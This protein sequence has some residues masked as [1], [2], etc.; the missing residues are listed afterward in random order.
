MRTSARARFL[1]AAASMFGCLLSA[2]TAAAAGD[3]WLGRDKFLHFGVSA[4]IAG[5]SYAVSSLVFEERWQRAV[6]GGSVALAA[7]AGKELYDL[8]GAGDASWKDFAWDV[9]GAAVGVGVALAI[10]FALGDSG[11]Q[12]DARGLALSW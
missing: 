2:K 11:S 1:T 12:T 5:T 4:A 6:S 9:A 7:G 3:D 10:D 8:S